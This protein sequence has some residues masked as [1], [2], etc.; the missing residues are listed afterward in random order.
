MGQ[1]RAWSHRIAVGYNDSLHATLSW[2]CDASYYSLLPGINPAQVEFPESA[3]DGDSGRGLPNTGV[4]DS[5]HAMLVHHTAA[6][7]A[8]LL[9][10][11]SY[12]SLKRMLHN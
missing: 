10:W 11:T 8:P 5:R 2:Y 12:A 4:K 7:P 9:V 3:P 6:R 1:F